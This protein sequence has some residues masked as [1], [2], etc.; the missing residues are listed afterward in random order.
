MALLR[1]PLRKNT[2]NVHLDKAKIADKYTKIIADINKGMKNSDIIMKY[3][4]S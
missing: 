2:R 1:I 3:G 4:I